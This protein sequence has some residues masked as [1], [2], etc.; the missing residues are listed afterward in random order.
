MRAC[1]L[2]PTKII[3]GLGMSLGIHVLQV[4]GPWLAAACYRWLGPGL[5][6]PAGHGGNGLRV[7]QAAHGCSIAL[8]AV[9][10]AGAFHDN[11]AGVCDATSAAHFWLA[12]PQVPGTT[13]DYRTLFHRWASLHCLSLIVL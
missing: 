6:L 1:M 10:A 8:R 12:A 7:W 9:L 5:L 13:G 11:R 4:A 2:A 3:A